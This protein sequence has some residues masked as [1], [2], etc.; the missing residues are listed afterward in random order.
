MARATAVAVGVTPTGTMAIDEQSHD[1]KQF[2]SLAVTNAYG[3][4]MKK[5][6]HQTVEYTERRIR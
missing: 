6:Q 4:L 1:R 2:S 5:P 3:Q